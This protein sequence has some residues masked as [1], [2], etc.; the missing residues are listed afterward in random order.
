MRILL[1]GATGAIGST[2]L[3]KLV[4]LDHP[5]LQ[6]VAVSRK[7][8][9]NGPCIPAQGDLRSYS[10]VSRI[11]AEFGPFDAT[12][13]LAADVR[14]NLSAEM[15][16]ENN[17]LSSHNIKKMLEATSPRSKLIFVSTAF[18][19]SPT[20][21]ERNNP[22]FIRSGNKEFNNSYEY[23][24]YESEKIFKESQL[25]HVIVRPS[26]VIGDLEN[27]SISSFNGIYTIIKSI[28][29]GLLPAIVG[30]PN[31]LIDMAPVD[32]VAEAIMECLFDDSR[33]G[34]TIEVVSGG[35]AIRVRQVLDTVVKT[36]NSFKEK[37]G[38]E[39]EILPEFVPPDRYFR[40]FRP[41]LSKAVSGHRM[42][43]LN[44]LEAFVPYLNITTPFQAD[45]SV[46]DSSSAALQNLEMSTIFW[47]TRNRNPLPAF[48]HGG[49]RLIRE[50]YPLDT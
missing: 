47:C 29:K 9:V 37:F 44:Q 38:E 32:K 36:V 2:F 27:G 6:I 18:A 39:P 42:K 5:D 20:V 22:F 11:G 4:D 14:W 3:Q 35:S 28:N 7:T 17:V 33:I 21:M 48:A 26:L 49:T 1:T 31:G 40:A 43:Y 45:A 8:R 50:A 15:A 19:S 46:Y 12:V 24:K 16:E 41:L 23:S 25:D 13:H 10:D 30:D 34:Q